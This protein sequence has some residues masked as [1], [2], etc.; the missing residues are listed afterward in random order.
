MLLSSI[1]PTQTVDPDTTFVGIASLVGAVLGRRLVI[2]KSQ[3]EFLPLP[4]TP[5]KY[6]IT[7][8]Q[9]NKTYDILD[10]G[11]A[12]VFGNAKL[13]RLKFG[14]FFPALHHRYPFISGAAISPQTCVEKIIKWKEAK[15]PVRV[16]ITDSPVNHMMAIMDFNYEERDG[17]RD[18]YYKLSFV[19]YK[20]L[21]TSPANNDKTIDLLTNLRERPEEESKWTTSEQISKSSEDSI[22]LYKRQNGSCEGFNDFRNESDNLAL[23]D[24]E[25]SSGIINS[26]SD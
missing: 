4:V 16:L 3:G 11:E 26:S 6:Q 23:D 25:F 9:Q 22:E 17:T 8:V 20:D 13:K 24:D 1:L 19:E 2:L 18:I 21:N 10:F 7:T 5:E 12:L 14:S 15:Q